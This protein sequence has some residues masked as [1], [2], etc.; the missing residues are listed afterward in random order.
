MNEPSP[1]APDAVEPMDK[2]TDGKAREM[3]KPES[4]TRR[5]TLSPETV[6]SNKRSLADCIDIDDNESNA[7]SAAD[8]AVRNENACNNNNASEQA[9]PHAEEDKDEELQVI[10]QASKK[11]R[12]KVVRLGPLPFPT[13]AEQQTALASFESPSDRALQRLL[14][15]IGCRYTMIAHQPEAVRAVAGIPETF[16]R[17]ANEYGK[18]EMSKSEL[19]KSIKPSETKTKGLLLADDMGLGKTVESVCGMIL[20]N[21]WCHTHG[22]RGLPSL[23]VAP[24]EAVLKQWYDTLVKAGVSESRIRYFKPKSTAKLE[25]NI[26]VLMT[27]YNIQSV[28]KSLCSKIDMRNREHPKVPLFPVA[29]KTLLHKLKNQ[30]QYVMYRKLFKLPLLIYLL[31]LTHHSSQ[32]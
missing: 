29:P 16:P 32:G 31:T 4:P 10:E 7:S 18:L 13:P 9:K 5:V 11:A 19:L 15:D 1:A 14:W 22:K 20:R 8:S 6:A 23:V 28:V 25:G 26:F 12:T 2:G 30:Y 27:R 24:N 21:K 3:A 17:S